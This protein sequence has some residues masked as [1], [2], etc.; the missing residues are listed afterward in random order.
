MVRIFGA[1]RRRT[2]NLKLIG[3][4]TTSA[5]LIVVLMGQDRDHLFA[6]R[7]G[8]VSVEKRAVVEANRSKICPHVSRRESRFM[9]DGG[10]QNLVCE[11]SAEPRDCVAYMAA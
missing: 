3:A 8:K 2:T 4:G 9:I 5:F 1:H 6:I 11:F 7:P 10:L